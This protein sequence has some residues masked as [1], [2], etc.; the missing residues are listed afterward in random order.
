MSKKTYEVKVPCGH[1][2][3][4][5]HGRI[6]GAGKTATVYNAEKKRIDKI[7]KK[8]EPANGN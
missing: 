6:I 3:I 1:T 4:D 7:T 2:V 5:T 8:E